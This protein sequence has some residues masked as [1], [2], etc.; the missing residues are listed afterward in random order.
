[1][2]VLSNGS[3]DLYHT[4]YGMVIEFLKEKGLR[5][6]SKGLVGDASINAQFAELIAADSYEPEVGS[7]VA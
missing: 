5:D 7:T 3:I 2:L 4:K 1:L 6:R